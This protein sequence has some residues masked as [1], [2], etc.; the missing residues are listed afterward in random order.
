[1]GK[2]V[3]FNHVHLTA[4]RQHQLVAKYGFCSPH[5]TIG[6]GCEF[7]S[8]SVL[9][10]HRATRSLSLL[11]RVRFWC[12][13]KLPMVKSLAAAVTRPDDIVH[14]LDYMPNLESVKITGGERACAAWS[15]PDRAAIIDRLA[16][17]PS[18]SLNVGNIDHHVIL[19]LNAV[20]VSL[21]Y[22]QSFPTGQGVDALLTCKR[23]CVVDLELPRDSTL[24]PLMA[25]LPVRHLTVRG[26]DD[27]NHLAQQMAQSAELLDILTHAK[28]IFFRCAHSSFSWWLPVFMRMRHCC[29]TVVLFACVFGSSGPDQVA[30]LIKQVPRAR[31]WKVYLS[32][33]VGPGVQQQIEALFTGEGVDKLEIDDRGRLSV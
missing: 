25:R 26:R 14:L 19:A 15:L 12:L 20:L 3:V 1:M 13:A 18:V 31:G 7:T 29:G 22:P 2:R 9:L 28:S 23:L 4:P 27:I 24:W 8:L 10:G 5:V 16:R 17:V 21:L 32:E 6:S 30:A 33:Y 11:H